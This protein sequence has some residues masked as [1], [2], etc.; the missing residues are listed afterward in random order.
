MYIKLQDKGN[1]LFIELKA[2]GTSD[3]NIVSNEY[4]ATSTKDDVTLSST[5]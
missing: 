1:I 2:L 4:P 3:R 5:K